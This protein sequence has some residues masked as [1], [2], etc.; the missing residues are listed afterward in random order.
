MTYLLFIVDTESQ[1]E[2][3][4][5]LKDFDGKPFPMSS[6]TQF[7]TRIGTIVIPHEICTVGISRPDC[8]T[9]LFELIVDELDI[10][11]VLLAAG[12]T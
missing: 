9:D 1:A 10:A 2:A 5:T 8:S 3:M 12:N 7:N 11:C 4:L 6:D